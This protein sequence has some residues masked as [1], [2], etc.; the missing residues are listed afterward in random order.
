MSI[1]KDNNAVKNPIP[2]A[3]LERTQTFTKPSE[4]NR[5]ESQN[6]GFR[7]NSTFSRMYTFDES[8]KNVHIINR[9]LSNMVEPM[10]ALT[11]TM[12]NVGQH[13]DP[14]LEMTKNLISDLNKHAST[15]NE[16]DVPEPPSFARHVEFW[17]MFLLNGV[18]A[19]IMGVIGAG[20]N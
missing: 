14:D 2:P 15:G 19:C 5:S 16:G 6:E 13:F 7:R 18:V 11:R 20:Y 8:G 12:S 1:S 17:K 4:F 10:N 3:E 9:S